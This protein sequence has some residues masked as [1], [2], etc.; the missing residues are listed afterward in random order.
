VSASG[1]PDCARSH[2]SAAA[3][4]DEPG[5]RALLRVLRGEEEGCSPP[6]ASTAASS[7]A[8]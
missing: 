5:G 1:R 6:P 2:R 4:L 7:R 3:L 8:R